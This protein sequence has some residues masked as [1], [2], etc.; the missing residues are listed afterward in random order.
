MKAGLK[1]LEKRQIDIIKESICVLNKHVGCKALFKQGK[2]NFSNIEDFVDDK[3]KS[4]LYKLKEM[5]HDLFRNSRE[6]TYKEKLYD[7]TVGYIFHEAMKLRENL[8]QLEYYRPNCDKVDRL[9]EVEKRIVSEIEALTKRAEKRLNEGFK[10]I[11]TLMKKLGTQLKDLIR[12]YKTN[13]LLPRFILENERTLI[14]IFGKKGYNE[15]LNELYEEGRPN[16]IYTAAMSYLKSEYYSIARRLFKRISLLHSRYNRDA[17]FLYLYASA[18]YYYLRN[19][20]RRAISFIEEAKSTGIA[21]I[22]GLKLYI[23][24][25][26]GLLCT[27]DRE[28]KRPIER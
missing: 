17:H 3:G 24:S 16:L 5:C 27:I 28:I 10:K 6:A 22:E 14:S 11:N 23:E 20:F 25:L 7:I 26:D 12:L 9:T 8:Y 4:C 2:L 13:Y 21:N 19:R 18:H 15:L 1:N